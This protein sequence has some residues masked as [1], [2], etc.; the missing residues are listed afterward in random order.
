MLNARAVCLIIDSMIGYYFGPHAR[1]RVCDPRT[2]SLTLVIAR[3]EW[4]RSAYL[5]IHREDAIDG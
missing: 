3:F 4:G 1:A 2:D 5:G